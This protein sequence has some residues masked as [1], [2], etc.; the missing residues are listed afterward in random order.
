[1]MQ[2]PV[3]IEPAPQGM[4]FIARLGDP[5]NLSA[6]ADTAAEAFVLL[7]EAFKQRLAQGAQ[8]AAL[9]APMPLIPS[10]AGWLPDDDLTREW[11]QHIEEYR[12]ACDAADRKRILG[13]SPDEKV[14][15]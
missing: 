5:F 1:M 7:Q 15:S 11:R 6:T 2:L 9:L 12:K 8:V 4:G 13:E 14:A 3:L 10:G